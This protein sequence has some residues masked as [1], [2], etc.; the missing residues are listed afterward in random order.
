[1]LKHR[2]GDET[3]QAIALPEYADKYRAANSLW[4][5][6]ALFNR[7]GIGEQ[8]DKKVAD[9]VAKKANPD[10][11]FVFSPYFSFDHITGR[12]HEQYEYN[13]QEAIVSTKKEK[14]DMSFTFGFLSEYGLSKKI[15]LGAGLLLSNSFSAVSATVVKALHATTNAYKFKLVTKYGL[16]EIRKGSIVQPQQGDSL[17]VNNGMLRLKTVSVPLTITY[18]L[19]RGNMQVAA[20]GGIAINQIVSDKAEVEYMAA[21]RAESEIVQNIEGIKDTYFSLIAGAE[22]A[23][24]LNKRISIAVNP[25]V[26]YAITPVNKGTPVKTYPVSIAAGAAIRIKL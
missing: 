2:T 25:V 15:A 19:K 22:I 5:L 12:F 18:H 20:L 23:F 16:A 11:P 7:D 10:H 3:E 24:S 1:M 26:R 6:P 17:V 4:P 9:R 8:P 13:D 21:D 14:P